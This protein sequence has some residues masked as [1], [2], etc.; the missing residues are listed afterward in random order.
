M[1]LV[2][3]DAYP[4]FSICG[5][6]YWISGE[7]AERSQ[8]GAPHARGP[9]GSRPRAAARTRP[10]ERIDVDR[11]ELVVDPASAAAER[12]AYDRLVV[13][14]GATPARPPIPG[15]ELPGVQLLHSIGDATAV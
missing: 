13:G 6:P 8:P 2:V 10:R 4:N 3:A 7:V 12:I 1:T 15:L 5:I 9:R 14:T 11:H